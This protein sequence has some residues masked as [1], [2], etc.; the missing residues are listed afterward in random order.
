LRELIKVLAGPGKGVLVSS[1][2][3]TEL[4]EICDSVVIIEK[5]K[6]KANGSVAEIHQKLRPHVRLTVAFARNERD[7]VRF[8]LEQPN[9]VEAAGDSST[10][11]VTF[12][13]TKDDQAAL[14]RSLV[15]AG[16]PVTEFRAETHDLEDIFLTL[17]EGE[18][19]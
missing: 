9:V 6:L 5:G 11:T 7:P 3:L 1:H 14:L 16:F 18:V 10:A 13:G 8:L 17:T 15:G 12:T 2:I 4:A 19:Q